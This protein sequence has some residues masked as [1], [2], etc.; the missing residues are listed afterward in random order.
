M[1]R[2]AGVSSRSKSSTRKPT[3]SQTSRANGH[4]PSAQ[5]TYGFSGGAYPAYDLTSPLGYPSFGTPTWDVGYY[6]Y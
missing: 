5:G 6:G 3:F 4:R 1:A 2:A